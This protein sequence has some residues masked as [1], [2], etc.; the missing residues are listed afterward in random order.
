MGDLSLQRAKPGSH[1]DASLPA[2]GLL[3]GRYSSSSMSS[4]NTCWRSPLEIIWPRA[5]PSPPASE[6]RR[7]CPGVSNPAL[8]CGA[9]LLSAD[10]AQLMASMLFFPEPNLP[11]RRAAYLAQHARRAEVLLKRVNKGLN[12]KWKWDLDDGVWL[13]CVRTGCF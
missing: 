4:C 7:C 10:A 8:N 5:A 9:V 11:H 12:L 2:P 6:E 3:W 1:R 13:L